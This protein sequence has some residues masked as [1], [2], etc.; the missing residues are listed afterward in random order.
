M[1][2]TRR[3]RTRWRSLGADGRLIGADEYREYHVW[4]ECF[5]SAAEHELLQSSGRFGRHFLEGRNRCNRE[6][7]RKPLHFEAAKP[8]PER[9]VNHAFSPAQ[10]DARI[11][12][13][14][15]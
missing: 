10:D 4:Y 5:Q 15:L 2:A 14:V 7:R 13:R 3:S 12:R 6:P 11:R 1:S 9:E 8:P